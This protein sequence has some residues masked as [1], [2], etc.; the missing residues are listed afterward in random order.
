MIIQTK[1][2]ECIS[3][4]SSVAS[5]PAS[6]AG[7]LI[8]AQQQQHHS[9]VAASCSSSAAYSSCTSSVTTSAL[10]MRPPGESP[11]SRGASSS[12]L[13]IQSSGAGDQQQSATTAALAARLAAA[14]QLA[15]ELEAD[16][17]AKGE[18][19]EQSDF[20]NLTFVHIFFPLIFN[21][22][23]FKTNLLLHFQRPV[24]GPWVFRV[25]TAA[26]PAPPFPLP[27]YPR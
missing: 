13:P 25:P 22:F 23:S 27:K 9:S 2:L 20:K 24:V 15:K 16:Q 8:A 19:K 10:P 5:L 4:F 7:L 1:C 11:L 17:Q 3:R 21:L 26:I 18:I 14:Q 6:T 12:S